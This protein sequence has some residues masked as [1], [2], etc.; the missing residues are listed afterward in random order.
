MI[1]FLLSRRARLLRLVIYDWRTMNRAKQHPDDM[2]CDEFAKLIQMGSDFYPIS[3]QYME[4]VHDSPVKSGSCE[5]EHLY[6]WYSTQG[7]LGAPGGFSR[8]KPNHSARRTY[9]RLSNAASVLHLAELA[10]LDEQARV[11]LEAAA[12]AQ[13]TTGSTRSAAAAARKE[14]DFSDI[15]AGLRK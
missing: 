1:Y 3:R 6:I 2:P 10:G 13:G 15:L 9:S 4:E 8:S 12:E 7:T 5:R 14:I 11:A